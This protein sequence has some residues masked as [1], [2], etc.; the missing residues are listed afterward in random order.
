LL[1]SL[2]Y[3]WEGG[4]RTED[5]LADILQKDKAMLVEKVNP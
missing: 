3:A 5:D 4:E 1:T 2:F